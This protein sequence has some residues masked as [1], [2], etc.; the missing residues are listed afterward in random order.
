MWWNKIIRCVFA[1]SYIVWTVEV[2]QGAVD[3]FWSTPPPTTLLWIVQITKFI[4]I[5]I[6]QFLQQLSWFCG[7]FAIILDSV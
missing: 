3:F 4:S 1:P 6:C 2:A 7:Y 5:C